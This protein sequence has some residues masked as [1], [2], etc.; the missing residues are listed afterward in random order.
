MK[1]LCVCLGLALC[2]SSYAGHHKEGEK[3]VSKPELTKEQRVKQKE[4]RK[5]YKA[6][7]LEKKEF[8]KAIRSCM[9]DLAPKKA[10]KK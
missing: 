8:W 1:L 3:K 6:E 7:G 9:G 5:K 4:C 2:V 10:K